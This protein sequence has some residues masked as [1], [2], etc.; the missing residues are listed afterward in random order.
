MTPGADKTR[1]AEDARPAGAR[2]IQVAASIL[3]ADF[4]ALGDAVRAAERG[5]AD[6]IHFDVM[7]GHFVPPI[8][9]GAGVVHAL[10]RVT[11]LPIDVHL[12]VSNPDRHLESSRAAS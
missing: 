2:R 6:R 8:T 1:R 4:A 10:R 7:D 5:G 11:A 3:S 12:M 9:L